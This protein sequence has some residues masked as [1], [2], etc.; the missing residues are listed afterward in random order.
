MERDALHLTL[1]FLGEH[2]EP[3]IEDVHFALEAIRLPAFCLRLAELGLFGEG[4]PRLLH[5]DVVAEPR[6]G[7]LRRRRWSR[8]RATQGCGWSGHATAR[9]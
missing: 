5:A 8:P 1:V 4:R 6:L 7:R 9:T 2:P 3:V